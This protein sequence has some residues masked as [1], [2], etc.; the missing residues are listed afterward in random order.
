MKKVLFKKVGRMK[1]GTNKEDGT[2]RTDGHLHAFHQRWHPQRCLSEAPPTP[3]GPRVLSRMKNQTG[4][5]QSFLLHS[6]AL[7]FSCPNFIFFV[8]GNHFSAG[9]NTKVLSQ[10]CPVVVCCRLA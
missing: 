4:R 1:T 2:D 7:S 9:H 8:S 5:A 3:P 6:P 10:G